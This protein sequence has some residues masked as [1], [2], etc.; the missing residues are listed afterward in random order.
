MPIRLSLEPCYLKSVTAA[1][2]YQEPIK[3]LIMALKYQSVIDV[4]KTL[5]R[6]VYYS[7][8]LPTTDFITAVPLHRRRQRQ[9][10]FNQAEVIAQELSKLTSRPYLP[11]II[12]TKHTKKQSLIKDRQQRLS[13]LQDCFTL[14]PKL[15][16]QQKKMMANKNNSIL[17][18][19]DVTTTGNT[20]NQCAKVL[21]KIGL[22]KVYG[23]VIAH[24]T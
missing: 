6:M 13:Q 21:Q 10:G 8:E 1:C 17:L 4:G 9:R 15:S 20:L 14:N 18:V 3:S 22:E 23:L 24:G 19:D 5:A 2:V 7:A 16:E 12:R 11:I